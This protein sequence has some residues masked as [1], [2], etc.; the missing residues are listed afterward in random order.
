MDVAIVAQAALEGDSKAVEAHNEDPPQPRMPQEILDHIVE[1]VEDTATIATCSLTSRALS[2]FA[3]KKRFRHLRVNGSNFLPIL[4]EL[5][6]SPHKASAVRRI[7]LASSQ[8][9]RNELCLN[10]L[11]TMLSLLPKVESLSIENCS[12]VTDTGVQNAVDP[13]LY[14][15]HGRAFPSVTDLAIS[16]SSASMGLLLSLIDLFPKLRRISLC[17]RR[18]AFHRSE[19]THVNTLVSS[20]R[21]PEL[22]E[23]RVTDSGTEIVPYLFP[24]DSLRQLEVLYL[25]GSMW[26]QRWWHVFRENVLYENV[27]Q[28]TVS[29]LGAYANSEEQL[30]QL[31]NTP[32]LRSLTLTDMLLTS[33]KDWIMSHK[34]YIR[35]FLAC[36]IATNLE[37]LVFE[38]EYQPL[39][40]RTNIKISEWLHFLSQDK[41]SKL[42]QVV[43]YFEG[44]FEDGKEAE[45]REYVLEQH[46]GWE[47]SDIVEVIVKDTNTNGISS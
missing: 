5:A 31:P 17:R 6:A 27:R 29:G 15:A 7:T 10:H 34:H 19:Q 40:D 25:Q 20:W 4:V 16:G 11:R 2:H 22:R 47:R 43:Y 39:A 33:N 24:G 21:R 23:L 13:S 12:L 42:S 45:I 1:L 26:E 8:R 36:V 41:F 28:I 18:W 32:N 44:A 30:P 35:H 37:K 38:F 3:T 14:F 46:S 9:L